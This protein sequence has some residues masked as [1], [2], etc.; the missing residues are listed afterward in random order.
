M[1]WQVHKGNKKIGSNISKLG[2]IKLPLDRSIV[3]ENTLGKTSNMVNHGPLQLCV[4]AIAMLTSPA[5]GVG[6]CPYGR[7]L[8][9]SRKRDTSN[10]N[11]TSEV[12]FNAL[13]ASMMST[14]NTVQ[15][16]SW[17]GTAFTLT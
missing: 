4:L 14:W 17:P 5:C 10:P 15:A 6:V 9:A 3:C 12:A 13:D 8:E 7:H 2:P 16:T 1:L 11:N